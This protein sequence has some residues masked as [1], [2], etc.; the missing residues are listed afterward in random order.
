M[1]IYEYYCAQCH[2]QFRHLA[3]HIDAPAPPCPRCGNVEVSRQVAAAATLHAQTHHTAQLREAS[4]QID[5]NDS[6]DIARFLQES[7][8]L[9][10]ADGVYGSN[11]YR[12]LLTRRA[13]GATDADV[14]DLVPGLVTEMQGSESS[15]MAGALMFS[16][17]VENR[18]GADGPPERHDHD[19]QEAASPSKPERVRRRA[20]DLGWA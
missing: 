19:A 18:M 7:G 4:R 10:D 15:Q 12:E 17:Q 6:Q 9:A 20:D 5:R 11:A 8:H 1:P 13:E 2:G 14:A 3:K 16:K